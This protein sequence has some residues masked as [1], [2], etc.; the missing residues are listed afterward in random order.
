MAFAE[1]RKRV[2]DGLRSLRAD[3]GLFSDF[4]TVR[5]L[6]GFVQTIEIGPFPFTCGAHYLLPKDG[7]GALILPDCDAG[8]APKGADAPAV[9]AY[10]SYTIDQPIGAPRFAAQ[11]VVK[12]LRAAGLTSGTLAVEGGSLPASIADTVRRELPRLTLGDAGPAVQ[13]ARAVKTADELATLRAALKLCDIGQKTGMKVARAGLTEIDVF[14]AVKSAM[15]REA[16]GR[17]PLLADCVCGSRTAEIGG[18][19]SAKKIR[20]GDWFILDLVPCRDGYW[21]DSCNT[22]VVG[23]PS[24][25]Q[26]KL[27]RE[28]QDVHERT[29]ELLKP[30]ARACDIDKACRRAVEKLGRP[31]FPHHTGH[32]LGAAWHEEPRIVPYNEARLEPDMIVALEPGT[33]APEFGG[34]RLEYIYR[35]T[36]TGSERLSGYKHAL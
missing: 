30:G 3:A 26:R 15:E 8:V 13:K 6:T 12:A 21:G 20:K 17:I 7:N 14:T 25:E 32:G 19:P 1:Q 18:P 5:Y 22:F 33:Y 11:A 2:R 23:E 10:V 29:R 4:T 34:L 9:E 24:K 31:V 36:K 35:I 16:G 28:I 27:F